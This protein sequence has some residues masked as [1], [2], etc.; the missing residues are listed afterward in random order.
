VLSPIRAWQPDLTRWLQGL[1]PEIE[2]YAEY[3][4]DLAEREDEPLEVLPANVRRRIAEAVA[5]YR[6]HFEDQPCDGGPISADSPCPPSPH[7]PVAPSTQEAA[8][9]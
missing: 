8:E 1:D 3:F 9:E 4:R 2:R 7:L 5:L 6:E